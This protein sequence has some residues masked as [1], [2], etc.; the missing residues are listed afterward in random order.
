MLPAA[1]TPCP[2]PG[3][4]APAAW[5][6]R[7]PAAVLAT[8]VVALAILLPNANLQA[9]WWRTAFGPLALSCLALAL[10][11]E[12]WVRPVQLGA[13]ACIFV[14]IRLAQ[15]QGPV[16]WLLFA[17]P[18]V[19]VVL[20]TAIPVERTAWRRGLILLAT[21]AAFPLT[22]MRVEH[23]E[24]V[25]GPLLQLVVLSEGFAR[26]G[27]R[28][29]AAA[30]RYALSSNAAPVTP[31]PPE[32]VAAID[33]SPGSVIRG[34]GWAAMGYLLTASH[35]ALRDQLD[36]QPWL[37][38][39]EGHL[40]L[41]AGEGL[42]FWILCFAAVAGVFFLDA[43][44]LRMVG[45]PAR[46]PI[47]EPWKA[48]NFLDYW[49]RANVYRYRML[50]E[51]YF[52][53]F[54]PARGPWFPF[55]VLAVFLISGMFH[56][57]LTRWPNFAMARWVID[58]VASAATAVYLQWRARA[59]VKAW[60]RHGGKPEAARPLGRRILGGIAAAASVFAILSIHGF[61]MQLSRPDVPLRQWVRMVL[62]FWP[63]HD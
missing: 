61:L 26:S 47:D 58:G 19:V 52:R 23:E 18:V 54:L 37:R 39:R 28:G 27:G 50:S 49:K 31:V 7:L 32:D 42:A 45:I 21:A 40:L 17:G 14:T 43:G 38:L 10:V 53:N 60:I 59:S 56:A 8:G 33:R 6:A 3:A 34:S 44:T 15:W 11:P 4:G 25:L 57:T 46:A 35:R 51:V 48:R 12:A 2:S 20:A 22:Q 1:A 16:S 24:H 41:A 29:L 5:R 63:R 13:L 55:S 9:G 36:L 30:A 62:P